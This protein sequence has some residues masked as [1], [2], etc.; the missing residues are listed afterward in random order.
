MDRD[1]DRFIEQLQG[2]V[3][4]LRELNDRA[5]AK[6]QKRLDFYGIPPLGQRIDDAWQQHGDSDE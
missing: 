5:E 1:L 4:E 2:F 6:Q 3:D